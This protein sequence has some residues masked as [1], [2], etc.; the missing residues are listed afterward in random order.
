MRLTTRQTSLGILAW[1]QLFAIT[2][3]PIGTTAQVSDLN[4]AEMV[5][6]GTR[7]RPPCGSVLLAQS[8]TNVSLTGTTTP[9][10]LATAVVPGQLLGT[11]GRVRVTL[12]HRTTNNANSKSCLVY[13]DT[14]GNVMYTAALSGIPDVFLQC[15]MAN[16][17]SLTSQVSG[18]AS[19]TIGIGGNVGGSQFYAVDTSVDRTVGIRGALTVSTDTFNLDAYSIEVLIP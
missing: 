6:T 11:N 8:G 3:A 1:A 4:Y 16:R 9:T 10:V 14:P 7:W 19:N 13:F 2:T 5:W 12:N 15:S 18:L 17:N